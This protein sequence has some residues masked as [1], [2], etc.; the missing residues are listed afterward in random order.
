MTL[1]CYPIYSVVIL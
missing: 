1:A